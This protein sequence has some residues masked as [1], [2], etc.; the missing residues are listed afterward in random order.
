MI[1]LKI[2]IT[3]CRCSCHNAITFCTKTKGEYNRILLKLLV[4][5]IHYQRSSDNACHK[6]RGKIIGILNNSIEDY[7][8]IHTPNVL[9]NFSNNM[10][11][12]DLSLR[13]SDFLEICT[14]RECDIAK[15]L[16]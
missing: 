3:N 6:L 10:D 12:N 8:N 13:K 5:E 16:T 9:L 14:C 11:S 15:R 2:I 1:I 4:S 7:L